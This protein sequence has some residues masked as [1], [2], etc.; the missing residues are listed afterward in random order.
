[1]RRAGIR[2]GN[3]QLRIMKFLWERD[4]A[5]A[6]E[7][8]GHLAESQEIAHSTV[9]TLLRKLEA[10]GAVTHEERNRV[11]FFRAAVREADLTSSSIHDLVT[12]AFQGSVSG[13]VAHQEMSELRKLIDEH[14][15]APR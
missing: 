7:I 14:Q 15:E 9:Q 3:V 10:K 12:R 6:R 1:M 11:F 13:L 2:L 4:A 8:T 5:T